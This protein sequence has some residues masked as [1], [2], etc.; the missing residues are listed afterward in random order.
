LE[1]AGR[2]RQKDRRREQK[3][4]KGR[5]QEGESRPEGMEHEEGRERA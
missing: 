5:E 1:T 3:G 2:K 4:A